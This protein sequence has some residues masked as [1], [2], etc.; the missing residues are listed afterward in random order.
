M[1]WWHGWDPALERW[2]PPCGVTSQ[3]LQ[4]GR[5]DLGEGKNQMLV[6]VLTLFHALSPVLELCR[7]VC[8][9]AGTQGPPSLLRGEH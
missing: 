9:D 5:R 1:C 2:D 3:I 8:V 4:G 6:A 7:V